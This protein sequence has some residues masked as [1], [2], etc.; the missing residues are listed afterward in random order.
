[1][2]A[3]ELA[4]ALSD[5]QDRT[6][7]EVVVRQGIAGTAIGFGLGLLTGAG[8]LLAGLLT[9]G[10]AIAYLHVTAPEAEAPALQF[11]W[12]GAASALGAVA[13]AAVRD[14]ATFD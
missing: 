12:I 5:A 1:V 2:S 10:A 6:V 8:P 3:S 4:A 7:V 11:A 9:G 13:G 14:V